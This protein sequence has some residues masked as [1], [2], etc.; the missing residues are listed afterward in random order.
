MKVLRV[1]MSLLISGA[2]GL[3]VAGCAG[4]LNGQNHV[5]DPKDVQLE[6]A[7]VAPLEAPIESYGNYR[8]G[9]VRQ[10]SVVDSNIVT[11]SV[12]KQIPTSRGASAAPKLPKNS[13][14]SGGGGR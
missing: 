11:K 6:S 10:S 12:P 8:P 9:S 14:A 2:L 13:K 4:S 5:A 3:I 7:P 1:C